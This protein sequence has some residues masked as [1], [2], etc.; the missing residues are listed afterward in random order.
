MAPMH[1]PRMVR[2]SDPLSGFRGRP[3]KLHLP[4][5]SAVKSV[6]ADGAPEEMEDLTRESQRD[7]FDP[8]LSKNFRAR[9]LRER[10]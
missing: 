1:L 3:R 2:N 4:D 7:T 9:A 8:W 6:E 10:G 5:Y